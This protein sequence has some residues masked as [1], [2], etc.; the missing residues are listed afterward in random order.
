VEGSTRLSV[1][2]WSD[3]G[4]ISQ[5]ACASE[6]DVVLTPAGLPVQVARSSF[7]SGRL[8]Q[9]SLAQAHG[10]GYGWQF[11]PLS[12][13]IFQYLILSLCDLRTCMPNIICALI[14]ARNP[15]QT[16]AG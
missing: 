1:V 12:R 3:V 5:T 16:H 15:D 6:R 7:T 2:R 10:W 4:R 9:E 13:H 11:S 14:L 8:Q